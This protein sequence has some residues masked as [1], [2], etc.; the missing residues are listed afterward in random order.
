MD[1]AKIF[2][3]VNYMKNVVS[4]HCSY[5]EIDFFVAVRTGL[6]F[7]NDTP[8]T[9]T[10]LV[11][12]VTTGEPECVLDNSLFPYGNQQL[13]TAHCAGIRLQGAFRDSFLFVV[14]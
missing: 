10:E 5:L 8:S 13:V 4:P 7:S 2:D 9:N 12:L 6:P 14:S 3:S 1:L 11:E